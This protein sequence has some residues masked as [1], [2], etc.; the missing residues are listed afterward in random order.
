MKKKFKPAKEPSL[1]RKLVEI[2]WEQMKQ[3]RHIR[4][5][6]RQVWSFEFL[7]AMLE[8]S[9]RLLGH[10]IQLEIVNKDSQK[11]IL[12]YQDAVKT[13]DVEKFDDNIFNHLDDQMAVEKFIRQHS[14]R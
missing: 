5:L 10:N 2:H 4:Q 8:R 11:I 7:C 3:R 12:T 14:V 9:G 1:L 6:S 13:A